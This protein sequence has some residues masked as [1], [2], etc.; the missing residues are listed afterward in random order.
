MENIEIHSNLSEKIMKNR[1]FLK[2]DRERNKQ[3]EIQSHKPNI[4]SNIKKD[5]ER[6]E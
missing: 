2:K 4:L 3:D 1:L 6:N 5:K